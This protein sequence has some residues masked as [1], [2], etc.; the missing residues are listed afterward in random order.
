MQNKQ[1]LHFY[2]NKQKIYKDKKNAS[3]IKPI[4]K[5]K[6]QNFSTNYKTDFI[7]AAKDYWKRNSPENLDDYLRGY[8][9]GGFG[10]N[11]STFSSFLNKI[12]LG[13]KNLIVTELS[14]H[15]KT[16]EELNDY[17]TTIDINFKMLAKAINNISD[18]D[19]DDKALIA[20]FQ[21]FINS[22]IERTA[23]LKNKK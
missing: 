17:F 14:K 15:N 9:C 20:F 12:F 23:E 10:K 2:E 8:S 1:Q 3:I 11:I 7:L 5:T 19:I 16:S 13:I 4:V 18:E 6:E 22:Y 21:G